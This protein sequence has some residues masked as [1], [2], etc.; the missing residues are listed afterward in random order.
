MDYHKTLSPA[1][2]YVYLISVAGALILYDLRIYLA[3]SMPIEYL[4]KPGCEQG[5]IL[6]ATQGPASGEDPGKHPRI[7]YSTKINGK[8]FEIWQFVPFPEKIN[9]NTASAELLNLLPNIGTIRA[10]EI[11]DYREQH[12]EFENLNDLE[13]IGCLNPGIVQKIKQYIKF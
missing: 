9:I 5:I 6:P 12:G 7:L 1:I 4:K 11:V 8:L 2:K 13:K 3:S 10:S